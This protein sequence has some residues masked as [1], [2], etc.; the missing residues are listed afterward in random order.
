M[1]EVSLLMR[2]RSLAHSGRGK[3]LRELAGLSL[4]EFAG[5]LDVDP[6][7]LS[8]WERGVARPRR[9]AAARWLRACRE[10][11]RELGNV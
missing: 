3:E 5:L 4:R 9:Y 8:R 2:G 7:T 11:E 1:G 6:A 10:I